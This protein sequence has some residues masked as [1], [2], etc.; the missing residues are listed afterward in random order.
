MVRYTSAEM[1]AMAI[2]SGITAGALA[3]QLPAYPSRTE[4]FVKIAAETCEVPERH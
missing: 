3:A 2:G 1:A 4:R